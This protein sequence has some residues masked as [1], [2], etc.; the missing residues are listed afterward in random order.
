M[1]RTP[2]TFSSRGR[3]EA[4]AGE[5]IEQGESRAN[6]TKRLT[7][8]AAE[9]DLRDL[10]DSEFDPICGSFLVVAQLAQQTFSSRRTG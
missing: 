1:A 5:N 4:K 10:T 6:V 7:R 2:R 9:R 8:K 3:A